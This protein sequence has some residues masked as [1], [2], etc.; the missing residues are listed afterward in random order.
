MNDEVTVD[1]VTVEDITVD[2]DATLDAGPIDPDKT[3]E[4]PLVHDPD[5]TQEN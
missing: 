4:S 1:N 5:K 3:T 2:S